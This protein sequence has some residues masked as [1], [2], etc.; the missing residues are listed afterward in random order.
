[1]ADSILK[2]R[3]GTRY[4]MFDESATLADVFAL[5]CRTSP[6][7]EAYREFDAATRQWIGVSW[8]EMS[9]RVARFRAAL[10]RE[11][12]QTGD[13]IAVMLKNSIDW[14]VA[15]QGAFAHGLVTVPVFV[16]DRADNV[17]FL[18]GDAG[19]KLLVIGGDEH[20]KRLAPLKG[21][22]DTITRI[23][24]VKPVADTS[25]PR[26]L[27]LAEWLD[28]EAPLFERPATTGGDLATI[29]Y[30]SGTTGKP[31][32]VMLSH[33]NMLANVQS[34]LAVYE[35]YPEDVFLSFLPLSHMF[36][37]TCD[38]YLNVVS[39][40]TI[41]FS[42]SIPQL[43]EDFRTVRPTV[44][45]SV[46]RIFDRFLAA[47]NDQLR[48]APAWKRKLFDLAVSVGHARFEKANGRGA[49]SP[50]FLLWPVL[51]PLI[52]DKLLERLG[53]RLRLAIAG[54][55]ALNPS[56]SRVFLG[57]GLPL[58]QGYGLTEASPLLCVNLIDRN[59]PHS[60]GPAV[61]GVELK[62]GENSGLLARGPN[63]MLGYWNN[64]EATRAVLSDDGWLATGDQVR[65]DAQGF[66]HITGRLKEIIVLGN[67][68][69]VPP[70]DMEMAIA[71]DPLFEQALIVGE[72]QA[73]LGAVVVLNDEEWAKVA[74]EA[75]L[76]VDWSQ[77]GKE[78]ERAEKLL[79]QRIGRLTKDFPGY[80]TI[81]KVVV[82][83]EK[84]T[85]DN[86]LMTPTLKLKRN[87]IV[88]RY[89][90]AIEKL[91]QAYTP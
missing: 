69:K 24:T 31:K 41:V 46:P 59:D 20:W 72:G 79:A 51:K 68:E 77:P 71:L 21:Q 84:W 29:V 54:G 65:I 75:K 82:A 13:R 2:N 58:C 55:A 45:F 60:V 87:V 3:N 33:R 23:V 11:G 1:M 30:T 85:V 63:V 39:G 67:G 90:E 81:R 88:N 36:E 44:I 16:D 89:S 61:P 34:G 14:I 18:L 74:A 35:V 76:Q 53:G 28:G 8:R 57:L 25:E 4:L 43:A 66:V 17:A 38:Y 22:L 40:A 73:F 48:K 26:L 19:V 7:A 47:I 80:A 50:G 56:V 49:W 64:P 15:D 70:V 6:N 9:E 12:L 5:R 37:R 78:R 52:A 32:G 10:Q 42:R 62:L 83:R 27:T 86:G 91:Y